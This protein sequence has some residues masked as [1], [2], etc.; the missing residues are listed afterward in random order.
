ML[1]LLVYTPTFH[2]GLDAVGEALDEREDKSVSTEFLI[3]LLE[4][5][6]K[7]NIFEFNNQLYQQLIGTAMGTKCATNYSNIFMAHR[8]DPEIIKMAIRYGK[9]PSLSDYSRG[10]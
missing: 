1:L 5:V 8:I 9:G 7:H 4:L 3:R 2:E 10:F 6:L